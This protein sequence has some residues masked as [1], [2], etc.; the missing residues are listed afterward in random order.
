MRLYYKI[1]KLETKTTEY[2]TRLLQIFFAKV[3]SLQTYH[4]TETDMSK[5][6]LLSKLSE[7]Q[8]RD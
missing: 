6:T 5:E 2:R 8:K 7:F 1:R 4:L 3:L